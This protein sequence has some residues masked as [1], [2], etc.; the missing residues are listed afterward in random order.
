MQRL[1]ETRTIR[2]GNVKFEGKESGLHICGDAQAAADPTIVSDF[3]FG[4]QRRM[5]CAEGFVEGT[6]ASDEAFGAQPGGLR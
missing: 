5:N 2:V 1:G 4:F 3:A 6:A